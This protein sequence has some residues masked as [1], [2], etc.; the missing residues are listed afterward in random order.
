[1]A[2]TPVVVRDD[3]TGMAT[4]YVRDGEREEVIDTVSLSDQAG[5]DWAEERAWMKADEMNEQDL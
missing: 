1:M 2:W 5:L 3:K 4:V